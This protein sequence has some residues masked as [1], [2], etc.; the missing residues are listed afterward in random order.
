[1]WVFI[2]IVLSLFILGVSAWSWQVLFQQKRA[3]RS[4]AEKKGLKYEPGPRFLS[5][6]V[7]SG[8]IGPYPFGLFSESRQTSDAR[9]QRFNTVIELALRRGLPVPGVIGT[10][11]M[12]PILNDLPNLG[13]VVLPKDPE[14]DETWFIRTTN[15]PAMEAYLTPA[16]MG[17]LKKLFRMKILAGMFLFD[18]QDA[19]LRVETADPLLDAA[20]IEKAVALMIEQMEILAPGPAE[21]VSAV[22]QSAP[23]E[24]SPQSAHEASVAEETKSGQ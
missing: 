8:N 20:K 2:W 6:P 5:S 1:M 11:A 24:A 3:W 22:P 12:L 10:A 16:R 23:A 17:V 13:R 21:S 19:I 15:A 4:F 14:W 7:V 18:D 9:G